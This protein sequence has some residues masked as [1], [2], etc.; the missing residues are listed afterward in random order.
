MANNLRRIAGSL[1]M[2]KHRSTWLTGT[3][4]APLTDE[5]YGSICL[6]G[7]IPARWRSHAATNRPISMEN[8]QREEVN[9][10]DVKPFTDMPGPKGLPYL[11]TLL[12]YK[13]G[14]SNTMNYDVTH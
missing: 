5:W 14:N 13:F 6:S 7:Y 8:E 11:G 2:R 4:A 1:R 12:R 9:S 3:E 10:K